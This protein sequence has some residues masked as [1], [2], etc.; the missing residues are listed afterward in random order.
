LKELEISGNTAFEE[1][2][3]ATRCAVLKAA[4]QQ[5]DNS[6]SGSDLWRLISDIALEDRSR[7]QELVHSWQQSSHIS[8]EFIE[9]VEERLPDRD[10]PFA[11]SVYGLLS[12]LLTERLSGL[13][14]PTRLIELG[15]PEA[16]RD[17]VGYPG[18]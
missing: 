3:I 15:F 4:T 16:V 13:G 8:L 2:N 5:G 11:G 18:T 9:A 10:D 7:G 14:D 12:Q 17:A 1:K 6:L